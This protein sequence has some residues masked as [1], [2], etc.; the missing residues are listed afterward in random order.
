MPLDGDHR[1]A[2]ALLHDDGHVEHRRVA[3]DHERSAAADVERFG[4]A[5]SEE[6]ARRIR[7]ARIQP[8]DRRAGRGAQRA[9]RLEL[10]LGGRRRA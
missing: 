1:A 2:Y 7:E 4:G 3:H 6:V 5:W 8:S 10:G 9:Q